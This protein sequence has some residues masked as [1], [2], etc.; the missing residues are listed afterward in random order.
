MCMTSPSVRT[1][2]IGVIVLSPMPNHISTNVAELRALSGRLTEL[3]KS[4][5]TRKGSR[6]S[7]SNRRLGAE[8]PCVALAKH[9]RSVRSALLRE[10]TKNLHCF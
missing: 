2:C 5:C 6:N 7:I 4:C 3:I 10:S 8:E 9:C 1:I